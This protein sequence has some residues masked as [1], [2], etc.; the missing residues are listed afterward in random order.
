M[1]AHNNHAFLNNISNEDG[2]TG[3]WM[4]DVKKIIFKGLMSKIM[5]KIFKYIHGWN[6]RV[7]IFFT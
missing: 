1:L 6:F 2:S 4:A 7:S 3:E 5:L